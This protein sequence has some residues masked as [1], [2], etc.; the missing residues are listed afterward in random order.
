MSNYNSRTDPFSTASN[1]V[2]FVFP[3]PLILLRNSIED[4]QISWK[5]NNFLVMTFFFYI[6]PTLE[7]RLKMFVFAFFSKLYKEVKCQVSS[8]SA[9]RWVWCSHFVLILCCFCKQHTIISS[10][11]MWLAVL[12]LILGIRTPN[13]DLGTCYT[14]G[15][16]DFPQSPI[17]CPIVLEN[18]IT[19]TY[20]IFANSS[21]MIDLLT[22]SMEQSP[23]WEANRFASSKEIR[24]ILWNPNFHYRLYNCSPLR[25][26]LP[27]Y[28]RCCYG[29]PE[30]N[31]RIAERMGPQM[32]TSIEAISIF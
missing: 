7:V 14:W 12:L 30:E 19:P 25:N 31:S 27:A 8:K 2:L 22:Y 9:E 16:R 11:P 32:F 26:C 23:S 18:T 29:T 15:L 1:S 21:H 3:V 6:V 4:F 20:Y 17:D 5:T 13:L 24:R 28:N 10:F